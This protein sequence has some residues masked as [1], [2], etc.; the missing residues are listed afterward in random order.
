VLEDLDSESAVDRL[1]HSKGRKRA[2]RHEVGTEQD[3]GR[4]NAGIRKGGVET[5]GRQVDDGDRVADQRQ[6]RPNQLEN[7]G[8]V[9]DGEM[10]GLPARGYPQL[11]QVDGEPLLEL[12]RPRR[13]DEGRPRRPAPDID[14]QA[15]AVRLGAGAGQS[16]GGGL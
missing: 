4:S 16:R 7:I 11:W 1:S 13:G 9:G 5:S 14:Q 10:A 15:R 12:P 6:R 2:V 8:I 3:T